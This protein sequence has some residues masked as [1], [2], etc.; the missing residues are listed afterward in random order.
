MSTATPDSPPTAMATK[1]PTRA[2]TARPPTAVPSTATTKPAATAEPS[3]TPKPAEP[4]RMVG[5]SVGDSAPAFVLASAAGPEVS[6]ESY[7]GDRNVVVVFY[8]AFW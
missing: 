6:L 5:T 2:P 1:P 7:R 8:R 4:E 3:P